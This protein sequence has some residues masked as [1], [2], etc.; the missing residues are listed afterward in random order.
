[1]S[2]YEE[3]VG[4]AREDGK[5]K[6]YGAGILSSFGESR[7]ALESPEP[8]RFGFDMRRVLR[9][10]YR[11]DSFQQAYFVIDSFDQLLD[12]MLAQPLEPLYEELRTSPDFE[13]S[14]CQPGD[15]KL[16]QVGA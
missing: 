16:I 3:T 14:E 11:S 15:R 13:P 9:T 6:I 8:N 1:M 2:V 7:F 12:R 4:L 5:L 10:R